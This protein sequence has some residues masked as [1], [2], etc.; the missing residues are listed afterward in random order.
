MDIAAVAIASQLVLATIII[1]IKLTPSPL[2][3][4]RLNR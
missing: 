3:K 4:A 2:T 1:A